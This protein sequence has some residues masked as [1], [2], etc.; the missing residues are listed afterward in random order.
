MTADSEPDFA[1]MTMEE[2]DEWIVAEDAKTPFNSFDLGTDEGRQA[3]LRKYYMIGETTLFEAVSHVWASL[4]EPKAAYCTLIGIAAGTGGTGK[5]GLVLALHKF[6]AEALNIIN[7]IPAPR[8]YA[9][10]DEWH[11]ASMRTFEKDE[12]DLCVL[13]RHYATVLNG[14]VASQHARSFTGVVV[15]GPWA[16]S[17]GAGQD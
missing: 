12:E 4:N 2:M 8:D 10:L 17:P 14:G 7:S 15:Q 13:L 11:A 5:R 1:A 9:S 6:L 3:L 16:P